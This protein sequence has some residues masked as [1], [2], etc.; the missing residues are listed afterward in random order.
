MCEDDEMSDTEQPLVATPAPDNIHVEYGRMFE[1]HP[2]PMWIFDLDTLAFLDV[3]E[4]A[5]RH[6][7][8]SKAEFLRMTLKD[9]RP[10]ADVPVLLEHLPQ[11][12]EDPSPGTS[13]WRHRKRDGTMIDAEVTSFRVQF[14]GRPA[15][16]VVV[17]DVTE[18]R[19]AEHTIRALLNEVVGAQEEERRRVARELHDD[20]AQALAS[21]LVGLHAIEQADSLASARTSA[22]KL[23]LQVARALEDIERIARGLRPSILDD[24]GLGEALERLAAEFSSTRKIAADLHVHG[25]D[26]RRLPPAVET[27]LYRIAQEA[28]TNAGKYAGA[29]VVSIVVRRASGRVQL[30]VED[31][32]RGFETAAAQRGRQ[33]GL[34]GMRERAA[35]LG[36]RF[37]VESARG[38]GTTIF[39]T[40]P[41]RGPA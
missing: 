23:R 27:T 36:G 31:D 14:A 5:V 33:L 13:A 3:N 6:Y 11:T 25:L 39:V 16:L 18:R 9:I 19:Q 2:F 38:Q 4:A 40:V 21:L 10:S 24:L 7:G 20:A 35:L 22:A 32:G 1:D 30:I 37:S 15:K 17:A 28:L 8:Y 29:S 12:F 26:D 34:Q 41:D